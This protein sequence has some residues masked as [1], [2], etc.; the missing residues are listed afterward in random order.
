[1]R[2]LV[3]A[4]SFGIGALAMGGAARAQ[5]LLTARGFT[6]NVA[7]GE[8]G[9]DSILLWTRYVPADGGDVQLTAELSATPDFR[10]KTSG[11]GGASRAD[12]HTARVVV[13]GL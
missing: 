13:G 10:K 4:G 3:L 12:D 5:A 9:P 8:P 7:S 2:S 6:H 11:G 1:R